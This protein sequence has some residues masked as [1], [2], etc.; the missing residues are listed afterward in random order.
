VVTSAIFNSVGGLTRTSLAEPSVVACGDAL[1]L[2]V[3]VAVGEEDGVAEAEMVVS[4]IL[5][6]L[7]AGEEQAANDSKAN[8]VTTEADTIGIS[9]FI[10]F[11]NRSN[12][13]QIIG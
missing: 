10:V 5:S 4:G 12:F 6:S 1:G 11:L 8:P 9:F 7:L 3:L 13:N 2:L